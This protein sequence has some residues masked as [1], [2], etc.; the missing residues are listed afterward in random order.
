MLM[1]GCCY[2]L[3]KSGAV[4]CCIRSVSTSRGGLSIPSGTEA[5]GSIYFEI[6]QIDMRGTGCEGKAASTSRADGL[7]LVRNTRTVYP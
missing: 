4:L 5:L 7:L 3:H 1:R 6:W 2:A